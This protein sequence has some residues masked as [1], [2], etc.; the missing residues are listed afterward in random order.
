MKG[1]WSSYVEE[2]LVPRLNGFELLMASYS[3]AHLKLEMLLSE[4]GYKSNKN[5]RFNI[6][7]TNTLEETGEVPN[8]FMSQWLTEEAIMADVVKREKPVM[9]II[10]NPPYSKQDSV[11]RLEK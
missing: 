10:G 3:M 5:Q 2:H 6:F 4:T 7:L 8:L 1:A 11:M 9:C